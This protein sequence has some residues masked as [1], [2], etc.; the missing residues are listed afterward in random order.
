MRALLV[1]A[2]AYD[3]GVARRLW[4]R[5]DAILGYPRRHARDEP[6]W[7]VGARCPDPYTETQWLAY[8]RR[9]GVVALVID[10]PPEGLLRRR[11]SYGGTTRTLGQWLQRLR[12]DRGWQIVR[13]L[14][15]EPEEWTPVA[16]RDG[17]DGSPDGRPIADGSE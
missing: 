2:T 7:Q 1:P 5:I 9:D 17:E 13:E 15:G 6:G 10:E 11:I 16:P 8:V 14:P 12:A 3:R 4:S